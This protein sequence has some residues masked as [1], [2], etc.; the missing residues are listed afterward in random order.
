MRL[1]FVHGWSVTNTDTYGELPQALASKASKFGLTI[2]IQHIYLGRYISFHD[3]VTVD[4]IARAMNKALEDLP[5]N[6][7]NSIQSFACITHSTGGPVVRHWV[8]RY[9]GAE[10]LEDAPLSHLVMLAPANHGS[11]LA[12]LGK[13][14][15]GRI[16]AWFEGVE[17]GQRV[18][19]WLC[20]GSDG[21]WQLNKRY[22]DYDYIGKGFY[23]F[24][25]TGQGIDHHF[26]DFLNRYLVEE[27][28]DGVVRVAGAN[29]NYQYVALKQN[30][31][32]PVSNRDNSY[33]LELDGGLSCSPHMAIGVYD[34]RSHSGEDMG[35]MRSEPADD[36]V[37]TDILDCLKVD[38]DAA[39]SARAAVLKIRT[40]TEQQGKS[41]YGMLVFNIHDDQGERIKENDYDLFLLGGNEYQPDDLPKGFFKDRQMNS[42]TGRLV[43]Y[44]DADKMKGIKDGKLGIRVVARPSSGFS[45]YAEAEFHSDGTSL[46]DVIQPNETTYVDITL[47]RFVDEKVFRFDL[48]TDGSNDFKKIKPSGTPLKDE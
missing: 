5:G 15:V 22:L 13:A 34:D 37:V 2:N 32:K 43:Y 25:L 24:V 31:D 14:R 33:H 44:L 1:I 17:P 48:A 30:I 38:N 46:S 28:S 12:A 9:F 26:Y 41:R 42:K 45:Y 21:Q 20:L 47:H 3:E 36:R 4:D 7:K 19:D 35:I 11:T 27:G 40:E 23:P 29:M 18:L 8:D 10:R 6:S 39:Y 16:Q